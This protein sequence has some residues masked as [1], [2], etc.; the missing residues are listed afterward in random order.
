MKQLL[1]VLFLIFLITP[2]F[3]SKPTTSEDGENKRCR[4]ENCLPE[5]N[6]EESFMG[7]KKRMQHQVNQNT[8]DEPLQA[9]NKLGKLLFYANSGYLYSKANHWEQALSCYETAV[10]GDKKL[11]LPRKVYLEAGYAYA[12]HNKLVRALVC[13]GIAFDKD[14][15]RE[16]DPSYYVIAGDLS[17]EIG[18][19]E[20]AYH[21]Y[22]IA[23]NDERSDDNLLTMEVY[24]KAAYAAKLIFKIEAANK[25]YTLA[26]KKFSLN[27]GSN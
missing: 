26:H 20:G 12:V 13:F 5:S 14:P 2:A 1:L 7:H 18:L 10:S 21:F 17:F 8:D 19:W 24:R 15:L 16:V 22:K 9:V 3:A 4:S 25:Y 27:V 23:I 11:E 6:P